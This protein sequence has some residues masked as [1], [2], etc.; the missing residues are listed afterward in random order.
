MRPFVLVL[1]LTLVFS[2]CKTEKKEPALF[3]KMDASD[4]GIRFVNTVTNSE[5]FNIFNYR[6]FYNGGGV[7]I[8][9]VNNDGLA[10]I[11][12][13]PTWAITRST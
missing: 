13:P 1:L 12:F 9:D 6:N 4:T 2:A 5:E 10:D 8:G 11:F 7:A 3:K